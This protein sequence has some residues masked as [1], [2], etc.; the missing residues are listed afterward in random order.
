MVTE[1]G[2]WVGS[3]ITKCI[4]MVSVK[5]VVCPYEVTRSL[6]K[7]RVLFKVKTLDRH[8]KAWAG[9]LENMVGQ[10]QIYGNIPDCSMD[11]YLILYVRFR[12]LEY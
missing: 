6:F 5:G 11:L 12:K 3:Y 10:A 9:N 8:K 4:I 2:T 1:M 7:D